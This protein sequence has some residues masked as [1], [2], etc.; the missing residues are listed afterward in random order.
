M[1]DYQLTPEADDDLLGV[2]RDTIKKWGEEQADLQLPL[3]FTHQQLFSRSHRPAQRP[4]LL[5][6]E[7]AVGH[8]Q[9][10][11]DPVDRLEVLLDARGQH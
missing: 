10:T 11:A 7:Q 3:L 1:A 2:A 9:L 8:P 5:L 4:R 6:V